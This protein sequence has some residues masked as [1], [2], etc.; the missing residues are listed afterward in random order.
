MKRFCK[1]KGGLAGIVSLLWLSLSPAFAAQQMKLLVIGADGSE[2]EYGAVTAMLDQIGVP[3]DTFLSAC[4]VTNACTL[5]AFTDSTG[6][7]ANY[8]GIIFSQ[9]IPAATVNG[10]YQYTLGW[11]G[12]GDW[13]VIDAFTTKFG[14]RTLVMYDYGSGKYGYVTSA[15]GGITPTAASP[16]SV[17]LAAGQGTPTSTVFTTIPVSAK[18]PVSN[19]WMV[20]PTLTAGA[21]AVLNTTVSGVSYPVGVLYTAPTGQYLTLSMEH[22]PN[23]I[24]T[25]ILSYDLVKWVTN[26]MFLGYKKAFLTPQ[27][28]DFF[29]PDSLYD[30]SISGCYPTS[31]FS[32]DP[33]TNFAT[34]PCPEWRIQANAVQVLATWQANLN[35]KAQTKNFRVTLAF[36]GVGTVPASKGG[37]A[38][39]NDALTPAAKLYANRFFWVSHTYD[40][41]NLD[42]YSLTT[43]NTCA[44]ATYDQ[45]AAEITRNVGTLANF[46][47]TRVNFDAQSMVTPE[48]SGLAN[49]AFIQAAFDNGVR[50]LVSDTSKTGIPGPNEGIVNA[51]NPAILEVP[52]FPTNIFYNVDTSGVGANGSETDEY[53]YL[54]GPGGLCVQLGFTC[55]AANQTYAQ[56]LTT[57]S[58]NLVAYILKG[59]ANPSM[60]HQTNLKIYNGSSSLFS[61]L[62]QKT[63]NT[64]ESYSNL[65]I[66]SQ[67]EST[68]GQLMADR[69][70]YNAVLPGVTTEW[71]PGVGGSTGS[72][73]VT[74][75]ST[76]T[77]PVT[78]AMTG[79]SCPQVASG[80][81]CETYGAQS[82]A[83][84]TF[85]S[86]M[87][88]IILTTPH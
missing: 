80:V 4:R 26:G 33:V 58:N 66:L 83:H 53:N 42:C 82:I 29:I 20:L 39:K 49:P 16:Q 60:F 51:L 61:D 81:V 65:P 17:T 87:S 71:T 64:F 68:I 10:V 74:V 78:L 40:H 28:D 73:S 84:L 37:E 43:S 41:P 38:P 23:L 47:A 59:Y 77:F 45:A 56:I 67:Q 32:T 57:E 70:A 31:S 55:F 36:N 72:V 44:P 86:G 27:V 62:M 85:S 12:S 13:Q 50:Y 79:I 15:Q 2:P 46:D 54:Y 30:K 19:A 52:R 48:V 1:I 35:S 18:I 22:N 34:D 21:T 9:G 24:H 76:A 3:Y 11:Y 7:N 25:Q 14:V 63:I 75:P 88:S 69:M 5:P 6:A 8:Y